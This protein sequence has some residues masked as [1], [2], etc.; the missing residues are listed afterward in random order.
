MS[1]SIERESLDSLASQMGGGEALK[2]IIGMYVDKLPGEVESL[3]EALETGDL[4]RLKASAHRLKS[5]SGQLG[6]KRLADLL[7]ELER[8]SGE[9]DRQAA[10][11]SVAGI[12]T[13]ARR[14]VA[15]LSEY[16]DG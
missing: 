13:E 7:A 5:S 4:E 2:R 16:R 12:E 10:A 6:A 14:V 3:R 15:D 1:D 8:Q 9:Q 11:A